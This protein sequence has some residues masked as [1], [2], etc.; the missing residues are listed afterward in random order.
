MD[1]E[2]YWRLLGI[3]KPNIQETTLALAIFACEYVDKDGLQ[4]KDYSPFI[5]NYGN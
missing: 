2:E 1:P 3:R 4:I 5:N